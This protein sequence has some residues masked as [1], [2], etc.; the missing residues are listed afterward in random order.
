MVVPKVSHESWE[1]V[2]GCCQIALGTKA[3]GVEEMSFADQLAYLL[4]A[5]KGTLEAIEE[6][7]KNPQG[8]E[9]RH[10]E[11]GVEVRIRPNEREKPHRP[12]IPD[13]LEE[14]LKTWMGE[15]YGAFDPDSLDFD[16]N[17]QL[18]LDRVETYNELLDC[19]LV[20]GGEA[21]SENG[22]TG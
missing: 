12:Q 6:V 4:R 5:N 11:D 1:R 14:D 10:W 8:Y 17:L 7:R 18:F 16:K 21:I 13:E 3:V 20:K 15:D 2:R 9:H 19:E 22:A